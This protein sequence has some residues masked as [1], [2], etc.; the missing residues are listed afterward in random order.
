M[1]KRISGTLEWAATNFNIQRGCSHECRYC[2]AKAKA[3]RTGLIAGPDQ[4]AKEEILQKTL[5]RNFGK[6][7]GTIM[8]PTSHD[9]T[10]S[11]VHHAVSV[12]KKM[13]QAG[14]QVLIVSKPHLDCIQTLCSALAL[15]KEQI[16]FRFTFGSTSQL[17]LAFWE[18]GAPSYQERLHSLRWAHSQGFATSVSMEPLLDP[19]EDNI[20]AAVQQFSP[21]VTDSIWLGK[22]N[23]PEERLR[24]NGQWTPE[25]ES[26]TLV[27]IQSQTPERIWA[28]Y[29][30]LKDH[31]KVKWKESIKEIVGLEAPKEPGLDI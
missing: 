12:L 28:L 8:F 3:V 6:R 14:N 29:Q 17:I 30:R 19:S 4:W 26:A 10:P 7:Q 24:E 5:T 16:L 18:P 21:F 20:V 23:R 15:Y 27:L 22:L 11:N 2:F 31:P 13:L 9:I 25:V 1:T